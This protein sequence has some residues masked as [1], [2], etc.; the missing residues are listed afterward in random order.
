MTFEPIVCGSYH[1][2]C[3]LVRTIDSA[4]SSAT[5][6]RYKAESTRQ[7]GKVPVRLH[8][9]YVIAARLIVALLINA[10][11]K[12]AAW[13]IA[14]VSDYSNHRV[15]LHGM[16]RV[17]RCL[18]IVYIIAGIVSSAVRTFFTINRHHSAL[19]CLPV[20]SYTPGQAARARGVKI[21]ALVT[22]LCGRTGSQQ[23]S[24]ARLERLGP[25][26]AVSGSNKS[27]ADLTGPLGVHPAAQAVGA[28]LAAV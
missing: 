2:G 13:G 7:T 12:K 21:V 24:G 3:G 28:I 17:G 25:C 26:R 20:V 6:A 9:L 4:V 5:L 16:A 18:F 15:T 14:G 11:Y 8:K 19:S 23:A 1:F 27:S 10:A 22:G